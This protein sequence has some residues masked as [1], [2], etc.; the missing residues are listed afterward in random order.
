MDV[1]TIKPGEAQP[2]LN[3]IAGVMLSVEPLF[4]PGAETP[5]TQ[6]LGSIAV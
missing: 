2:L 6:K 5:E 3:L 4:G 1:D